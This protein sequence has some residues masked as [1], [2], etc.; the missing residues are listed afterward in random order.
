M[1]IILGNDVALRFYSFLKNVFPRN[2]FARNVIT[3]MTGTTI[4]Q[5]IPI[6]IS[7][8]L[9]RI[10]TPDDFGIFALY[11]SVL[12]MTAVVATARYDLAV[13]LPE[14][15]EDAFSIVALSATISFFVSFLVLLGV[16]IFNTPIVYYLG[17]PAISKWLYFIPFSLF[18]SGLYSTFTYWLNRKRQYKSLAFNRVYQSSATA[19]I[20][21]GMGLSVSGA[22]GLVVASIAGQTIATGA[23]GW[24]VWKD[25][26]SIMGFVTKDKI[27]MQAKRYHKFPIYSLPADFVNVA[28]NQMPVLLLNNFFGATI[29]GFFSLTQRVLGTPIFLIAQSILGVFRERAS[30]DYNRYGNCKEIYI[31][32]FKTLFLISIVPFLFFFL[33]APWLFTFVFGKEWRIAGDFAQILSPL[34]LLRFTSSPLSYVFFI[35][36]KQNYDLYGQILLLIFSVSSIIIGG[37]LNN[38]K[39]S[40]ICFSMSY[41]FI[42]ILYLLMS[43]YFAKGNKNITG[44][45]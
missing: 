32:T 35:A 8:I 42:Y 25:D 39:I 28:A 6:A 17:S 23:L 34:F 13:M 38:P 22:S 9:T 29:V 21:L 10:Y 19:G 20:N 1:R 4:A 36:E 40:I 5:A 45:I 24:Q 12:S 18:L 31:K 16:W 14:K 7:P 2:G 43:Y 15:D 41:S 11:M 37:Y 3:L 33:T 30:S 44:K 27:K 26:K